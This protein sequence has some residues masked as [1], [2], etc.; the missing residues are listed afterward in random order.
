MAQWECKGKSL[1]T[2]T[3]AFA[4][5]SCVWVVFLGHSSSSWAHHSALLTAP[6][7]TPADTQYL[8]TATGWLHYRSH[9]LKYL[10][11]TQSNWRTS[12]W[13]WTT[14]EDFNHSGRTGSTHMRAQSK[15]IKSKDLQWYLV[16]NLQ[17]RLF[18]C[19]LDYSS[20]RLMPFVSVNRN[21]L[22]SL[23]LCSVL[24]VMLL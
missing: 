12:C 19:P 22:F 2:C 13:E 17:C 11:Q 20:L 9:W 1:V 24:S 15:R 4:V 21:I 16:L 5:W 14:R 10:Q 23:I 3:P 7:W 8:I 6:A 18:T